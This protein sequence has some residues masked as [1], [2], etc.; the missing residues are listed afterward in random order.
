MLYAGPIMTDSILCEQHGGIFTITFNRAA[1][2][3]A[4]TMEMYVQILQGLE[5]AAEDPE[6]R[7]VV[8][9]GHG[10]VFTAGNDLKDFAENPIEGPD[11]DVFRLLLAL[12]K[13]E[14]P[15]IA[16]V[17]GIA[18]GVGVTML[19]HCDLVYAGKDTAFLLPFVD[20]ALVPE[21]GSTFLL[22]RMMGHAK[23]AEWLYFGERFSAEDAEKLGLISRVVD[24]DQVV[25]FAIER[26]QRLAQKPAASLRSTKRLLR[27][28]TAKRTEEALYR[29]GEIFVESLRSPEAAEA[30]SAF[31]EKRKPD[32]SRFK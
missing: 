31:F 4:F 30:F 32:F 10:G 29:E 24:E 23:A 2:K 11:S 15:L 28:G 13:F 18:V 22:P 9:R 12:A 16:A 5:K 17:Q 1:K 8:L 3:N 6:V 19:L 20:L 27:Q 7:V 14:K 21:G 25:D 26:A